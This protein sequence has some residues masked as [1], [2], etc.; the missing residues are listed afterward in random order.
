M[1]K[2]KTKT[3]TKPKTMTLPI[4]LNG[5]P[6]EHEAFPGET[7]LEH[8]RRTGYLAAK[9]GCQD[10]NCGTCVV[11]VDGRAVNSCLMLAGQVADAEVWTCEGI[12]TP[13]KPHPIQQAFVDMAATQCGFCTP[14][15]IM[16]TKVLLQEHPDPTMDQIKEYLDGNLCRCTGY[17]KIFDAVQRSA[18]ALQEGDSAGTGSGTGSGPGPKK[19]V[20][21]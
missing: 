2:T 10:G 16:S 21:A 20:T 6:V 7:L 5:K 9:N 12:G 4:Q 1:N 17:V 8:L 11:E 18:A 14:G 19:E 3:R 13:R 15:L